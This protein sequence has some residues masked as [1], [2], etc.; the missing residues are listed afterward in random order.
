M[1]S[2]IAYIALVEVCSGLTLFLVFECAWITADLTAGINEVL[3][4]Y[5]LYACHLYV[6]VVL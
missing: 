6:W 3:A 4:C 2:A 5:F 1:V